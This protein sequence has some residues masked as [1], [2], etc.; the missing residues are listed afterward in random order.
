MKKVT[1][2]VFLICLLVSCGTNQSQKLIETEKIVSDTAQKQTTQSNSLTENEKA[3]LDT[4]QQELNCEISVGFSKQLLRS[5]KPYDFEIILSDVKYHKDSLATL[6]Q[7][8]KQKYYPHMNNKKNYKNL[9]IIFES[10]SEGNIS[11][12]SDTSYSFELD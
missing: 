8:I 1:T 4:L 11:I 5:N 10:K 9:I 7:Y 2:I 12:G 3:V 6:A